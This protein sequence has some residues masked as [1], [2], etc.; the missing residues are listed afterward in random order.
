MRRGHSKSKRTQ[1]DGKWVEQVE[2]G[3]VRSPQFLI[4]CAVIVF[5]V[6]LALYSWTLAPTVT[7]IDSGELIV[8]AHSLGVAHPPGT[9]LWVM[10]AHLAS[11][12][13]WGNVAHRINFSS[14]LFAACA[15]AMLILVTADLIMIAALGVRKKREFQS[16][17]PPQR[18]R[19]EPVAVEKSLDQ[20][21]HLL[22][23][24]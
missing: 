13:P 4:V 23:S 16:K 8:V 21:N 1:G 7:L 14:A 11:L 10:L 5:F 15:A 24:H 20:V 19:T 12:L 9:P 17:Q 18:R 22:R 2:R 3:T 6:S